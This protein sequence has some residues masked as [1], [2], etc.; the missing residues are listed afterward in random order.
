M[1]IHDWTRVDAGLFH[2]FH[3][4]W[5]TILSHALNAGVLPGMGAASDSASRTATVLNRPENVHYQRQPARNC[6][7]TTQSPGQRFW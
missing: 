5:V 2:A 7:L 3:H 6:G 1:P 4:G